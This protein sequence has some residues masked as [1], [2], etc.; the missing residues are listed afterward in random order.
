MVRNS[1]PRTLMRGGVKR[2]SE[3]KSKQEAKPFFDLT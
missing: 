3:K 2:F 1:L